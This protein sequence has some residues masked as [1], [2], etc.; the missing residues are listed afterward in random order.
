MRENTCQELDAIFQ[1][2]SS[3]SV[4]LFEQEVIKK[5]LIG[6]AKEAELK[7]ISLEEQIGMQGKDFCDNL[8]QEGEVKRS[9]TE[10]VVEGM[11]WFLIFSLA[12]QITEMLALSTPGAMAQLELDKGIA[13]V[14]CAVSATVM[15][16]RTVAEYR[17]R[18]AFDNKQKERRLWK[19]AACF[20]G[21][22][23]LFV[24][25]GLD[26][27]MTLGIS[28]L[29]VASIL[30]ILVFF[31]GFLRKKYWNIQSEKYSWK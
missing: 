3:F 4:S 15:E 8:L 26:M 12:V 6:I 27:D 10:Y 31:W 7:G 19:Y 16:Y 29:A 22:L 2:L 20:L 9:W 23:L 1:Y 13:M 17:G 5:E 24:L 14:V 21:L 30:V 11:F 25:L 18:Q 28:N